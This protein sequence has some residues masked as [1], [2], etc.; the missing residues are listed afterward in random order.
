M[1]DTENGPSPDPRAALLQAVLD[2][3]SRPQK[4]L[5]GKLLWDETGS[6]L[7]DR[8][9]G[10]ADYYPTRTEMALLPRVAAE[11]AALMPPGATVVEF[12]SG[13]SRK[14]R[15]LLDALERPARFIALDISG[16]YLQAAIERL[17]PDYPQV[18]MIPVCADYSQPVHL[19]VGLAG[20]PVLG[21]FP[22][23]SI[24]NFLPAEAALFLR[25]AHTTLGPS[26]FLVGVDPTH[27]R[28]RLA[29][30]YGD[31]DGLMAALHRN[32]LARLN[33]ECDADFDPDNFR[34]EARLRDDPFRV[35]AHLTALAPATYRIGPTPIRFEAGESIHTDN[36]HKYTPEAFRRLAGRAGWRS[37]Q[38]WLDPEEGFSLHL[39]A[40]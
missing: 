9:C 1:A 36:S 22:G 24:G 2:G 13:A 19:P 26:R 20:A 18:E 4:Q 29:R 15:T 23:T 38:V 8:I 34:H 30:A 27:D 40:A 11:V 31:A 16:A 39:L 7:F 21:F 25:R 5:P 14:I 12:G 6:D 17:A 28:T 10:S 3:L 35:E 37:K 33:R 32:L